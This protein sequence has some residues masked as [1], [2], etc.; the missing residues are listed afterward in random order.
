MTK[1]RLSALEYLTDHKV[2]N[3]SLTAM[4]QEEVDA[5]ITELMADCYSVAYTW[6]DKER[7]LRISW[8]HR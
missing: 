4:N 5:M 8:E 6:I 1:E 2:L 7:Y 3:Y